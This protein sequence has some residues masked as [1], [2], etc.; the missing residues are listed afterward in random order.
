LKGA[1]PLSPTEILRLVRHCRD[2]REECLV[3]IG[4]NLGLRVSEL[5]SLRWQDVMNRGK[6]LPVLYL[7]GFR[8][9]GKKS[10]AIP[11]N[12]RAA[13]AILR[14]R[15]SNPEEALPPLRYGRAI[16]ET[17]KPH[18]PQDFRY[19]PHPRRPSLA[20]HPGALWA[21]RHFH[22]LQIHRRGNG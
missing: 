9:K 21:L 14:L 22:H 11:I 18:P 2:I 8:T 12:Q 19:P 17:L 10:R 15:R 16:R 1:R 4:L 13:D 7:E 3:L 6:A 5:V 20:R